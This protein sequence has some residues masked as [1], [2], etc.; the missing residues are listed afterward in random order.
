MA[1][2]ESLLG[3]FGLESRMI[4]AD[5]D[6]Q[7]VLFTPIDYAEVRKMQEKMRAKSHD[8]LEEY[9]GQMDTSNP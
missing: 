6:Y 8:F 5:I 1:R 2:F 4:T 9:L 7:G 3:L